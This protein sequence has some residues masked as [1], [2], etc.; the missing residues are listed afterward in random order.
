MLLILMLHKWVSSSG[1]CLEC[2]LWV[3]DVLELQLDTYS[4]SRC[5][6]IH[7]FWIPMLMSAGNVSPF[8]NPL[9]S[10]G[11]DNVKVKTEVSVALWHLSLILFGG[12]VAILRL[13]MYWS[14]VSVLTQRVPLSPHIPSF[15]SCYLAKKSA[16]GKKHILILHLQM[17]QKG[18]AYEWALKAL[19]Q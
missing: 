10:E 7:V 9:A 17:I 11:T 1:A 12:S 18:I 13:Q 16:E 2:I 19:L 3:P 8:Q 15:F 14:N 6:V 4:D 5:C